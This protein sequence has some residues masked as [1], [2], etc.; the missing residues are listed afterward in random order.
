MACAFARKKHGRMAMPQKSLR[1]LV[2]S[3]AAALGLAAAAVAGVPTSAH[4][5]GGF[6]CNSSNPVNQ[7]AEQ[8]IFSQNGDG[9]VTAVIQINYEGPSTKFA[10]L[11]PVQGTPTVNVSS[12]QALA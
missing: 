9:T 4:A 8:I 7:A 1:G 3:G 10:W 2:L 11:L 12:D 5:C 6:F